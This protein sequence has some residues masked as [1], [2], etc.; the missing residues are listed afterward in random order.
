[1]YQLAF[2]LFLIDWYLNYGLS[3]IIFIYYSRL[4]GCSWWPKPSTLR[5][6]PKVLPVGTLGELLPSIFNNRGPNRH[7]PKTM[8][9]CFI[10]YSYLSSLELVQVYHLQRPGLYKV[11]QSLRA[12]S[13]T[14]VVVLL[15]KPPPPRVTTDYSKK[16]T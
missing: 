14:V 12:V 5:E 1:M 13:D 4:R 2:S 11:Y 16:S 9:R 15:S 7:G 6:A 8:L 10:T 3:I